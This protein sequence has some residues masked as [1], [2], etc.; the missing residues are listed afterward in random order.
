M[1]C[2]S[3]FHQ[4]R[5]VDRKRNGSGLGTQGPEQ[6][7]ASPC[8]ASF[9]VL[10]SVALHNPRQQ[11]SGSPEFSALRLLTFFPGDEAEGTAL[12]QVSTPDQSW[13]PLVGLKH[14][15]LCAFLWFS[16]SFTIRLLLLGPRRV[17]RYPCTLRWGLVWW[18]EKG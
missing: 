1:Q 3:I 14:F 6:A 11:G 8:H 15:A 2:H 13:W 18:G 17:L 16:F 10:A 5:T 9:K 4:E 7:P 12:S